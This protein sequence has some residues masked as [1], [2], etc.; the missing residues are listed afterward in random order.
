M[1]ILILIL[2][3][4][5]AGII[6]NGINKEASMNLVRAYSIE[7]AETFYSYISQDLTLVQK[8]SHSKAIT[9]W[10]TNEE[11]QEKKADAFNEMMDIAA[12]RTDA[13]LYL[14]VQKSFNEYTIQGKP[15]LEKFFPFDR[16]NPERNEDRWY[17]ECTGSGNDYV[18]KTDIEKASR[19]WRLWINHKVKVDGELAGVFCSGLRVP[20]IFHDIFGKYE[21]TKIR[22]YIIDRYGNVQT[23]SAFSEIYAEEKE[24]HIREESSDPAFAAALA[25]YESRIDGFFGPN[26]L[27]EVAKLSQESFGYAAI[28][29]I[30]NTD[31]SVVVF[32]NSKSFSGVKNLLPFLLV[33]LSALLLY[34]IVRDAFMNNLIFVPLNR[35]TQSVSEGKSTDTGFFGS[36]RDDELG[37]LAWT[38]H[39][40]S[41]KQ[42]R[43]EKLLHAVNSVATVL[44]AAADKEHI[45]AS[46]LEGMEIIGRCVDIDRIHI[47][48]N[49]TTDGIFGYINLI[50][51]FNDSRGQ[52]KPTVA[53]RPYSENPEWERKFLLN[54]C[55][56]GP[57]SGLTQSEQ[58]ILAPEGVKSILV[59]PLYIQGDFY[60]FFSF[61]DC[62]NSERI[63]MADEIDLLRSAGLM[64]VSA[65]NR[66]IQALQLREAQQHT[67]VLLDA[68]PFTCQL[69]NRDGLLFD[70]NEAAVKLLETKDKQ[71]YINR[72]PLLSP[73]YQSDGQL[74]SEKAAVFIKKAFDT[75]SCVFEWMHQSPD[76]TPI[77]AEV[78]LV[79]VNFGEEPVVA[80]FA[81]DLR[82]YKQMMGEIERQDLLL[83]EALKEAQNASSAKSIFLANM[84]HEMR[85]P[86]N[87]V[88]G[89]SELTLETGGL[90][91]NVRI[92][93]E[94]IYN[95][96][97][98]LLS[99]VNDILDISKIE[100]GK[101]EL[102][103]VEYDVPS[104]LNDAITQSIL[105]I[106]EKPIQ[107]N[108]DIN[109]NLPTRLC[110]DDL[111]IKQILNNLLSNAFKYTK[112]GTVELGVDCVQEGDSVLL[113]ARVSDSGRGIRP[114]DIDSLFTDYAM[115]DTKVNRK[116]EGTGLGLPIT[117]KIVEMMGGSI[118]VES[119]YGKGSIFTVRIRQK[120]VS[121]DVIGA[122]L[123]KNLKK[124]RYSDNKRNQN[125]RL[126]RIKLPYARVLV[127]DDV[128]TNLDVARGMMKPY[129]MQIDCVTRGQEAIDAIRSEKVRYN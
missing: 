61:D 7:A 86:L 27:P 80:G 19:I 59:I 100:A 88:L 98:T 1:F 4:G 24:S 57:V 16:L 30:R 92:N 58:D 38:I 62:R 60:G 29:P 124:F 52:L 23:D 26:S 93:L 11:D 71:D 97:A 73:E 112:E 89:F 79:R 83:K 108:L 9:A 15:L 101:L 2:M 40:S 54:E 117:K 96:G 116:I 81:R 76:G 44:L 28:E 104:L 33:M 55:V 121:G 65:L 128:V 126:M 87:A 50:H 94:K 129:G 107:F 17:F 37:E 34:G 43:Q 91:E 127:V 49:E 47:W 21:E 103:P 68:M 105:R 51:W 53:M 114:E 78:T 120:Y 74:S 69:W 22:G 122:E 84:S 48:K 42:M 56:N 25:S 99:T 125:L 66:N 85:T 106:G 46:L 10:F 109:E 115:M 6:I 123:V 41:H 14:G 70:C 32:Y 95:A 31:W 20:D 12:I 18:L 5:I 102:V 36:D 72:F 45:Q 3:A 39:D 64:M 13:H 8:A 35:L 67:Q 110:G 113:T 118:K 77:P 111:R 75:G 119:E 90:N 82:E 63:F